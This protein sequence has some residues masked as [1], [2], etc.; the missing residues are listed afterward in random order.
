MDRPRSGSRLLAELQALAAQDPRL[1]GL[2]IEPA[3][4]LFNCQHD[5]S[6]HVRAP[7]KTGYM[8]E[9]LG[10]DPATARAVLEFVAAHM[11]S[12]DG[13]VADPDRILAA[14]ARAA[15]GAPSGGYLA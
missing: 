1:A 9:W 3:P 4:C 11:A 13:T 10:A 14:P 6:A 15:V 2:S 7:G 5:C 8:L 12:P